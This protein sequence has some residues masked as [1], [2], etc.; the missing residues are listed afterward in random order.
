MKILRMLPALILALCACITKADTL[1]PALQARVDARLADIRAWAADPAVVEAVVAQN[2]RRPEAH[3]SMDQ[4]K[5]KSLTVLDPFVRAFSKNAAGAF[6]KSRKAEWVSEA[7]LSDAKG[8]KVAF[9]AKPTNWCHGGK[10]KHD[11]PMA[12]ETWQGALELDESSG[13][14]QVQVAVPVLK[15]G[16]P[17]GV[18][19]VG[20]SLSKLE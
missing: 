12:G 17:V 6:L 1:E 7:F 11:R 10:P 14:Q 2:A 3:A 13:L 4:E 8:D 19:T 16:A 5:W 15:D 9:L 20:L 18:L